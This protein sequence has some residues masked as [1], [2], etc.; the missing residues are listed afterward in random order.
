MESEQVDKLEFVYAGL[1]CMVV[2]H[3]QLGH[4]CGYVALP[5]G[6][7]DW[8]KDY[9]SVNVRVHGSLTF[10]SRGGQR[11]WK[12]KNLWWF[13]FD[14]AHAG[15]LVPAYPHVGEHYWTLEEVIKETK[16]LAKQLVRRGVRRSQ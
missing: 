8:G 2:K 12:G 9:D 5:E 15:D 10:S 6:H 3:P 4:W 16:R 11:Y 7:P 14:C 1:K 13:G